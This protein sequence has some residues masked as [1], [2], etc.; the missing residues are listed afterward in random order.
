MFP[1]TKREFV[2]LQA[3]SSVANAINCTDSSLATKWADDCLKA[4]DERFDGRPTCK[5]IENPTE[6]GKD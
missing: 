6:I 2:W 3:W 5:P 1:L 4:F